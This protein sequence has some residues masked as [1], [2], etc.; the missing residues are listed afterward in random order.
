MEIKLYND[1]VFKWVFGRQEQTYPL[2]CFLNAVVSYDV[3]ECDCAENIKPT[4]SEV[5]I[6]NPYDANEPFT[7]E[8]QGI[9]DVRAKDTDTQEW[10]DLEVQVVRTSDYKERSKYYLAGMYRDQLKKSSE[11]NYDELRACYGIHLLVDSIFEEKDEEE[12]WFNHYRMLNIRTHQPLIN[13][14]NLYYV[15]LNKFLKCFEKAKRNKTTE[16]TESIISFNKELELWSYFLGTIQDNSKPLAPVFNQNKGIEE[17]FNMLQTF[18]KDD[19][20]REQYR[21]H[22]EFLRVQRGE[23]ARKERLRQQ[24]TTALLELEKERKAKEKERKSKEKALRVSEQERKAKEEA[25]RISEQE[26]KAKEEALR[27]SEQER[28]AKEEALRKSEEERKSKEEERKAKEEALRKSEEER[29]A[30]EEVLQSSKEI[31]RTAIS[32]LKKAGYSNGEIAKML[33]IDLTKVQEIA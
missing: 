15:E 17:V 20:L 13:H 2:I 33:N 11:H 8:K 6:L 7:N 23:E 1:V 10:I 24:Y 19:R 27:I 16:E 32:S 12:F 30:K 26:R 3:D 25:L 22:E 21:L 4:F 5:E 29:K 18:T 28:K 14:W 31:Q 9:L